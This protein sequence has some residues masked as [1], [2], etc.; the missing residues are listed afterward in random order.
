MYVSL[1][2][3]SCHLQKYYLLFTLI[4]CRQEPENIHN[5]YIYIYAPHLL[6]A[7]IYDLILNLFGINAC[8]STHF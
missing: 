1:E 8:I 5:I 6:T 4:F 3:I 7:F 2:E